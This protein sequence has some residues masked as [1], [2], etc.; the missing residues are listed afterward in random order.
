VQIWSYDTWVGM[1]I[2]ADDL[3]ALADSLVDE[4]AKG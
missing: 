4:L 1:A 2:R 3:G